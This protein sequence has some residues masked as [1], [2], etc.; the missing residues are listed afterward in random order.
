MN[1]QLST[2]IVI[3]VVFIALMYFLLIR[4]QKKKEKEISDMR[5]SIR[6]GDQIITIGGIMGKVIK[7]KDDSIVIQVG[8]DKVRF[9]LKK[10]AVSS[11]EK[12]SDKPAK[13]E[14]AEEPKATSKP[15]RLGKK[16]ATMEDELAAIKEEAAAVTEDVQDAAAEAAEEV[17]EAVESAEIAE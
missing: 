2:Q 15:K 9:E 10:W 7:T 4:P 11:I 6:V 8:A 5:S 16:E 17:S 12:K 3:L 13:E 1:S 14:A